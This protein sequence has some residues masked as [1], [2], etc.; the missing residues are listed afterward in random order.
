MSRFQGPPSRAGRVCHAQGL[1]W[2][3]PP[4]AEG[5]GECLQRH[6]RREPGQTGGPLA[7]AGAA[8]VVSVF[9]GEPCQGLPAKSEGPGQ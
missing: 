8:G 7:E 4:H 3:G 9:P 6:Q 5:A 2:P 1:L